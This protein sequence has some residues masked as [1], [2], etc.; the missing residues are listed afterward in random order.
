M[1]HK[2]E[3]SDWQPAV[4]E[5]EGFRFEVVVW[6]DGYQGKM[7]TKSRITVRWKIKVKCIY[8]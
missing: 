4:W 1:S 3:E 7:Q 5:L 2:L 8:N 6:M